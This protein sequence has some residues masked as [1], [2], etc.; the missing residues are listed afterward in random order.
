MRSWAFPE[1]WVA[2]FRPRYLRVII[3]LLI[4]FVAVFLAACNAPGTGSNGEQDESAS[5]R[6]AAGEVIY[7]ENCASCHGANG[8]GEPNWK[9]PKEDGTYPAPPH[10]IDG[11]TWHHG[12]GMIFQIIKGGGD[13]LNIP[14]FKSGMPA[15]DET[16][17]DEEI[18]A[19]MAYLKSLWP[20]EQRN[21]QAEVSQQDPLPVP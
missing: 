7:Q 13:S 21:F 10:T 9:I 6:V 16:L 11:H 3:P 1:L 20:E 19:V 4:I 8:E 5:A 17:S 15:F 14:K 12:D 2:I 18:V